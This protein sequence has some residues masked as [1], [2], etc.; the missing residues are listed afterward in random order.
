MYTQTETQLAPGPDSVAQSEADVGARLLQAL[1][2][3]PEV[4]V[5][6]VK[7]E[8]FPKDVQARLLDRIAAGTGYVGYLEGIDLDGYRRRR[9]AG[10]RRQRVCP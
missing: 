4:I 6:A 5:S 8:V 3:Q 9:W 10:P 2:R 7:F 1:N